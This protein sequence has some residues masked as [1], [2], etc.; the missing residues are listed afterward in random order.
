[1]TVPALP[2]SEW[3]DGGLTPDD[4][5]TLGKALKDVGL[6]YIAFIASVRAAG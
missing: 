2:G 1:M 5:V 3:A 4:A 6:D